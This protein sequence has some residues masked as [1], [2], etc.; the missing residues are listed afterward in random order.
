MA[1]SVLYKAIYCINKGDL[2][3][4]SAWMHYCSQL[5]FNC[6]VGQITLKFKSFLL[7]EI[8][9]HQS[10]GTA[11]MTASHKDIINPKMWM[12]RVHGKCHNL[13]Y[14]II[15]SLTFRENFDWSNL[16]S[17]LYF[18]ERDWDYLQVRARSK[19]WRQHMKVWA[20]RKFQKWLKRMCEKIQ[21][22]P[23]HTEGMAADWEHLFPIS[24]C[25]LKVIYCSSL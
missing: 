23:I 10:G 13:F 5:W 24:L 7:T 2:K 8:P 25:V 11:V 3:Q 19:T 6:L 15:D 9:I 22:G 12:R 17:H 21:S 18:P 4:P 1:Q 14:L 16:Q 20:A